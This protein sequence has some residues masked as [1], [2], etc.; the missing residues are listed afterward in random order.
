LL[1]GLR[2]NYSTD[3]TNEPRKKPLDVGGNPGHVT[4][5]LVLG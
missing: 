3:F 4:L 2:K 5:G 1:A